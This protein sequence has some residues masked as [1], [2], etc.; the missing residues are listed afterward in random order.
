[1]ITY[2]LGDALPRDEARRRADEMDE[3]SD[4]AYRRRIEAV[5]DAG[6]GSCALRDPHL[7]QRVIENWQRFHGERYQLLAWVVMPNHVHVMIQLNGTVPLFRIIQSWKSYT[8]R[9]LPVAWQRE[10]WDRHIRDERHYANAVAYIHGNPVQAGLCQSPGDWPW[11]SLGWTSASSTHLGGSSASS[12][13][14]PKVELAL[15]PPRERS[16]VVL[17]MEGDCDA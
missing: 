5:L 8:G 16:S 15:D 7:A 11:S 3:N 13:M 2:R 14:N 6:H 10:Y 17:P 1:M 4:V 12:T 9:R